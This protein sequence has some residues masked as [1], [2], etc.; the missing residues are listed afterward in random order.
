MRDGNMN[1]DA[2][3]L[4]HDKWAF[5]TRRNANYSKGRSG[6]VLYVINQ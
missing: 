3:C 4:G 1:I 5:G 6:R 2:Y